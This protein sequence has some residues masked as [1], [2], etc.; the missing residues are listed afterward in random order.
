[1][2]STII[3]NIEYSTAIKITRLAYIFSILLVK[4]VEELIKLIQKFLLF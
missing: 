1:M 3:A 4:L 2:K